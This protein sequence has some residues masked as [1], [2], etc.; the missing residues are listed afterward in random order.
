[1]IQD[2]IIGLT[3]GTRPSPA[4]FHVRSGYRSVLVGTHIL[5]FKETDNLVDV[6][7]ILH[8]RMDPSQ[9]LGEH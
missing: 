2:T 3:D 4:A 7:R 9:P 6:I 1:M 5:F 8:R